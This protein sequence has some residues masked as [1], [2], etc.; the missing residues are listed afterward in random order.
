[1]SPFAPP[2]GS[3]V[4]IV[5]LYVFIVT[6]PVEPEIVTPV[7]A[8]IEVTIP[9]RLVPDPE[10]EVAVIIPT[11]IFGAPVNPCAT[12]DIPEVVAYPAVVAKVAIPLEVAKVAIPALV[13]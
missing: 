7:P 2:L 9:V 6:S 1:M 13:A 3:D 12:V 5:I 10:N 11:E 8:T 4:E